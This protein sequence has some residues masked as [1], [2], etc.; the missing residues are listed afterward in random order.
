MKSTITVLLLPRGPRD[1][2]ESYTGEVRRLARFGER[3]ARFGAEGWR[4]GMR[5]GTASLVRAPVEILTEWV[6]YHLN[7]GID[8]MVIYFD[9]PED[10]A[11]AA[12]AGQPRVQAIP[13]DDNLWR[14]SLRPGVTRLPE[15][16]PEKQ[17]AIMWH[18]MNVMAPADLDWVAHID[19]D[20]LIWAPGDVR[21]A[22]EQE[23][24]AGVSHVQM[25]P[26]EAVPPRLDSVDPFREF[27]LF[28]ENRTDRIALAQR[29][30]VRSPFRRGK[31]FRGHTKGKALVCL[32][33]S[34]PYIR[35]HGPPPAMLEAATFTTVVA[36]DLRVLHYDAGTYTGWLAKWSGREDRADM[37]GHTTKR[38]RRQTERFRRES[39]RAQRR[40]KD[41]R[42]RQLF[43]DEYMLTPRDARILRVLGLARRVELDNRLFSLPM[44][45]S[46]PMPQ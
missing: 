12:L 42:L 9:D 24:V 39:A 33:G 29:L 2:V 28:K 37:V 45:E 36:R 11:I 35:I 6:A 22:L 16:V 43:R 18:L 14:E 4:L 7:I 5:I 27:T 41:R 20:E 38:R 3:L 19:S 44:P 17:H 10:P 30:G 31:Y 21:S 34:V 25:M 13:C 8:R 1:C 46:G 32:D 26:M 23:L 40:G 15:L